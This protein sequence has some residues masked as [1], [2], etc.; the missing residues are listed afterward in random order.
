M[1]KKFYEV[2][3]G[4][5]VLTDLLAKSREWGM[6][7]VIG[8]Q[9]LSGLADSVMANTAIKIMVGGAGLREDYDAFA[10]ATG[11]TPTKGVL[12]EVDS[13]RPGLCPGSPAIPIHLL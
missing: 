10:G 11:M 8:T 1:F 9:T 5:Y 4:T 2:R 6:G 3:E 12:E 13:S 7:F